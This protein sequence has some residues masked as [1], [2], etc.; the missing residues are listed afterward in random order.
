MTSR[1]DFLT[2]AALTIGATSAQAK[3]KKPPV[4]APTPTPSTITARSRWEPQK[5]WVFAVGVL[6]YPD[7][8]AWPEAGRRD[9]V[10]IEQLKACGVP[11]AQIV[12][13]KDKG[14]TLKAVQKSFSEFLAKT[15]ADATLWFYF[16]GHGDKNKSGTG[17]LS[18]YDENWSI[19][20][21]LGAIERYFVGQQALLFADCCYS[22]SLGMEAMLRAGRVSCGALT[23]SLSSALSTGAWTFTECL[24]SA[25]KGEVQV[26]ADGDGQLSFL[27]LARF[28]EREMAMNDSQL[29]TFAAANG[30]DPSL[31]LMSGLKKD[32]PRIGEYLDAKSKDGKFYTG[33]IEKV[34]GSKFFMK[35]VGYPDTQNEWVSS[36]D[37][38]AYVPKQ[39]APGTKVKAEWEGKWYPAEVL[40]GR[41][42]MHLIHYNGFED[43]WD[44]WVSASRLKV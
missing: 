9:A 33:R 3:P 12:F 18:L 1:R 20:L 26:D 41:L 38:R 39:H 10:M 36:S 25:L 6:L 34:D 19:P 15:P 40:T 43:F 29:S 37:T 31:V 2:A 30:F 11:E 22:G 27:E 13:I 7:G 4:A 14:A 42:G 23:S 32:N 8:Q 44:E 5:T 28:A 21:M 17:Q 16:A 24:I 35:W